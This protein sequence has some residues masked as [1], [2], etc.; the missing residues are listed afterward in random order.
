MALLFCETPDTR[1]ISESAPKL[2]GCKVRNFSC[3]RMTRADWAIR[4]QLTTLPTRSLHQPFM[5]YELV[6]GSQTAGMSL[7]LL[8]MRFDIRHVNSVHKLR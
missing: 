2:A 1:L 7:I 5:G 6:A 8:C 3:K 4:F